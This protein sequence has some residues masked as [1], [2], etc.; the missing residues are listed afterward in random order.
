MF[1]AHASLALAGTDRVENLE[2]ALVRRDVIGQAKGILMNRYDVDADEAFA[3]LRRASQHTNTK[4]HDVAAWL[5]ACR[6]P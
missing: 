6:N 4:L 5:V 3:R 2:K 1:V